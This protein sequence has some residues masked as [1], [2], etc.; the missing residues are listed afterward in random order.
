MMTRKIVRDFQNQLVEIFSELGIEIHYWP[1]ANTDSSIEIQTSPNTIVL[2][3]HESSSD[4]TW[5]GLNMNQLEILKRSD[6]NW[7]VVLLDH[8][9]DEGYIFSPRDVI[10]NED[11]WYIGQKEGA[12][13]VHKHRIPVKLRFHNF[14][15][16][17]I[18]V[19]ENTALA[20]KSE[21]KK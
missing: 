2:H 1:Q 15:E 8:T 6:V 3:V 13:K 16:L 20:V 21:I 12:Y 19:M 7:Y 9:I 5:W 11:R 10:Q 4:Q 17:L 18:R 14:D